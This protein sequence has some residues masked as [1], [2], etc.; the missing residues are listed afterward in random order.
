MR[1]LASSLFVLPLFLSS[2]IAADLVPWGTAGSWDVMIDPTLGNGCLIQSEFDDG[3]LVRIGFDRT[4]DSGYLM[5]FN[6][7][8]GDIAGGQAYPVAFALDG[9]M[10]EGQAVGIWL[11]DVP[12]ADIA[13]DNTDFLFDIAKRYTMTLFHDGQEVMAI[14]LKGSGAAL[15]AAIRC[16]DEQG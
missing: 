12:G 1:R 4:T 14:D 2:A 3:S 7:A 16:Q 11:N 8:W 9:E 13:F 5:A 10:Y 6:M 15:E